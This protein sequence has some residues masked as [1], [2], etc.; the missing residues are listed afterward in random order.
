MRLAILALIAFLLLPLKPAAAVGGYDILFKPQNEWLNTPRPLT[1]EDAKGRMILLDF[2]TY[3]CINCMQVVPDLKKLEKEFGERLLVIGV[4]S[5]KFSGEKGSKRILAAAKRFGLEHPVVNDSSFDVWDGFNVNAWPTQV[6]LDHNGQVVARYAGEGHY[7][8]IRADMAKLEKFVSKQET[9]T[10]LK[11]LKDKSD[12][13]GDL[14][15]PARL[16]FAR[17]TPFGDL[18][19]VAD[20][21]HNRVL[22]LTLA[23]E[24]KIVIGSGK[25]G[26]KDGSFDEAAFNNPR[27]FDVTKTGVYIAD[28]GNHKLRFADF[29]TKKVT[30]VAGTGKR[31]Y[32]RRVSNEDALKASLASP[33][34]VQ[35]MQDGRTLAIA[36]AGLHQLWMM[37][38][39]NGK[40]SVM[41]GTGKEYIDDGGALRSSLSQPSGLSL[42]GNT[43]YFVDA[44]TS[45]LRKI[46][47]GSVSTLIGTGLFDF[48][49]VDG[50]YPKAMMQH[51][52]GLDTDA[53]RIFIADTY[54]NALRT[55]DI[56]TGALSTLHLKDGTLNEPGDVLKL[57]DTLY[58]ADTNNHRI[59]K[60][61]VKTGGI[62]PLAVK[63]P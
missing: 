18:L 51:A 37:D 11:T 30:T 54:N 9:A 45:S 59:V 34:D 42:W 20:G 14:S 12:N 28:T 22:G 25:E 47:K 32:D 1:K 46:E 3:G 41:A 8:E 5:A 29:A 21:G 24:V 52:Q 44:E 31:G 55:Y 10:D 57:G 33:W 26:A 61:D 43:L 53:G 60:V 48:G 17:G 19:F 62:R 23:G 4:H 38:T 50:A 39:Q 13:G 58:V 6:L 35:M 40:V 7:A 27:G 16:S 15:F 63:M 36:M 49:L 2:W 56:K